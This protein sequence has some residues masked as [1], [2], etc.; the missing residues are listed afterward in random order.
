MLAVL[1][2]ASTTA[3]S[4]DTLR[5]RSYRVINTCSNERRFLIDAYMGEIFSSDSLQSFDITIGYD[6]SLIRPTDGLTVGTLSSQMTFGDVSPFFNFRIPGE[7]RVGAFTIDRNV[8]GDQPFFAIAGNFAGECQD[9]TFFTFPWESTFNEEFRRTIAME[10]TDTVLAVA[11]PTEN[12]ALGLYAA[13]PPDTIRGYDSTTVLTLHR[14]LSDDLRGEQ[15]VS[16]LSILGSTA[17]VIERVDI[18]NPDSI[19]FATDSLSVS[20]FDKGLIENDT[21][22][23]TV[24]SRSTAQTVSVQALTQ[25]STTSQCAC[26]NPAGKDT[27]VVTATHEPNV[28]IK[29]DSHERAGISIRRHTPGISIQLLHG[30]PTNIQIH[31]MYGALLKNFTSTGEDVWIANEQLPNG[32][33]LIT[34]HSGS[35]VERR[36]LLK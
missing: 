36:L 26:T 22:Y 30:Q 31:S 1:V 10:W 7:M 33:F 2:A 15:I 29:M 24:R 23:V 34:V 9:K 12:P 32:P 35:S 19:V 14:I 3:F 8:R 11:T 13:Q 4:Q 20:I 25:V 6:T 17:V 21:F 28:S 18:S 16:T 27:I 5:V